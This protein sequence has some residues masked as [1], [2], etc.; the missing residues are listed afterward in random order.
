[1]LAGMGEDQQMDPENLMF[2]AKSIGEISRALK[3]DADRSLAIKR[4]AAKEAAAAV[5][6]IAAKT[7]A[8][9]GLTRETVDAIK[10][11]ILGIGA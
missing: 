2:F 10:R 3:T 4:E 11:E 9:A 1:M 6:K 5:D 8:A 7:P